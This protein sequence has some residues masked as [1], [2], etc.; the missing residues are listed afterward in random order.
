[1]LRLPRL[2]LKATNVPQGAGGSDVMPLA[3]LEFQSPTAA[4]IATPM[5][6]MARLTTTWITLLVF[7][8]LL[9]TAFMPSERI[10]TATGELVATAPTGVIQPF[11]TSIVKSINVHEGQLV[12][13]GEILASLDPTFAAADLTALTSQQQQYSAQVAELQ[14]QEDGQ[15]YI[16]D[17]ANPA[18]A[19]QAQTYNQMVSQ[20]TFTM[21][22]YAQKIRALQTAVDGYNSQAAYFRQRLSVADNVEAMRKNL[23]QLQVGSKLDT[24]AA[25]DD[26]LNMQGSLSSAISS[27]QQNERDLASQQAERDEFEQQWKATVSQQLA[28]A[29]NN[30]TTAQQ[31]LTKAKL[32]D[33]LVLLTAPQDS[34]VLS[35][36]SLSVG[37]VIQS[38]ST[39]MQ[40]IPANSPVSV[41]AYLSGNES[42]YVHVGNTV[43]VKFDTL[44]FNQFGSAYGI[45]QSISPDSFNP[46]DTSGPTATGPLLPG[47]P[48][49]LYYKAEISLEMLKIHNVPPGF[50]MVPGMPLQADVDVGS[51]SVM[52]YFTRRVTPMVFDS[53]H[54]P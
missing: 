43:V 5:P 17:S 53:L 52:G 37:S 18:A 10:V 41:E 36:A 50:R 12:H 30:L 24:L 38:G 15:P 44:P 34:I 23:Q 40:L 11:N 21:D 51:R 39:L 47:A 28:T 42:G 6:A 13:K 9:I 4:I 20:Y 49:T 33:Q 19:L 48:Q 16:P 2:L 26:R 1:M 45:V 32:S 31:S 3:L 14:A 8:I 27:A 46:Q 7:S 29:I 25:T 54:E 35:I 22:D